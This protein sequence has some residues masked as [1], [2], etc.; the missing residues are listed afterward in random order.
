[1][2]LRFESRAVL[3]K[4]TA[5]HRQAETPC[6]RVWGRAGGVFSMCHA[7]EKARSKMSF[8]AFRG[9][10]HGVPAIHSRYL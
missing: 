7:I 5:K 1:M 3:N 4:S 2:A 6:I 8:V 9:A 10:A